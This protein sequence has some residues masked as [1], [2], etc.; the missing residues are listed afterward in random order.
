MLI[1]CTQLLASQ[2]SPPST[3][4]ANLDCRLFRGLRMPKGVGWHKSKSDSKCIFGSLCASGFSCGPS[5]CDGFG[6]YPQPPFPARLGRSTR[7]ALSL[8]KGH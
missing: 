2:P 4:T 8:G 5:R 1:F 7:N 6:I 3:V